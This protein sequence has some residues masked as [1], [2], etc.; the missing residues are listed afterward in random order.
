MTILIEG[1]LAVA[2]LAQAPPPP[3]QSRPAEPSSVAA[4]A[5]IV[6]TNPS[7]SNDVPVEERLLKVKRIFVESFG[8][9]T[10]SKQIQAMVVSS[11]TQS[12]KFIVTENRERADAVLKGSGLEKTSQEVH[13][14]SDST[15]AGG[16][17]GGHSGSVSGH[18]VNGTGSVSGSSSG[19][20]V[21][22]AAAIS[23]SSLNT[24][25]VNDARIAVRLVDRD[26]DVIWTTTQ[27][28]KG[29]KYKSATADVADNVVKQ[30]VRD[31]D[32]ASKKQSSTPAA[33]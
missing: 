5:P 16:A 12:K 7:S 20:F 31:L 30:L 26:G 6:A 25:T 17:A 8:D 2:L 14:Y 23:D 9:D 4:T 32:K 10:V 11:L 18:W 19:G 1:L 13:A 3:E 33:K 22:R 27:E 21:S 28:S 24:E 15:A 29:A